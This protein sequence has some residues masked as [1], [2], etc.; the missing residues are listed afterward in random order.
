[1]QYLPLQKKLYVAAASLAL[2]SAAACSSRNPDALT[3]MNVDENV[4][5]MN[6]D[7]INATE[8]PANEEAAPPSSNQSSDEAAPAKPTAIATNDGEQANATETDQVIEPDEP[9]TGNQSDG[10]EDEPND[11]Y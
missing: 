3:G 11:Q 2:L 6:D 1:M 4:A 10:N 9:M 8:A 5:M 7:E